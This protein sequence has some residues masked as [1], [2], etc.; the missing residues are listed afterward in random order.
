M[1]AVMDAHKLPLRTV[2]CHYEVAL[3][4]EGYSPRT[5][6]T[7]GS[8]LRSFVRFAT[9]GREPTLADLTL[10][11]VREYVAHLQTEH[12]KFEGHRFAPKGGR[13]SDYT[14]NLHGRVLRAF[15]VWL[16]REGYTRGNMLARFRPMRP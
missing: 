5:I 6:E 13:L 3:T 11:R 15:A 1:P 16:T 9:N 4:S 8:V 7:N 14:I 10:G 12:V 2:V